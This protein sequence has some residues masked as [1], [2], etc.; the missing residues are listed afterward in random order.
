VELN[1]RLSETHRWGQSHACVGIVDSLSADD[2]DGNSCRPYMHSS[3]R[4]ILARQQRL[5][6]WS[7]GAKSTAAATAFDYFAQRSAMVTACHT[8]GRDDRC[9]SCANPDHISACLL[10]I[11]GRAFTRGRGTTMSTHRGMLSRLYAH[12]RAA[13]VRVPAFTLPLAQEPPPS[14]PRAGWP[15][16]YRRSCREARRLLSISCRSRGWHRCSNLAWSKTAS[17]WRSRCQHQNDLKLFV[18]RTSAIATLAL[19]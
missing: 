12:R 4:R 1:N 6:L 19:Y 2:L 15:N 10:L 3:S 9:S 17:Q 8:P 5:D 13:T 7:R 18:C 14:H 16:T 11:R